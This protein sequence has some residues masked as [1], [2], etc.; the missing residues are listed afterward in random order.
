MTFH[1]FF[2]HVRNYM[3]PSGLLA[4]RAMDV[5]ERVILDQKRLSENK[6]KEIAEQ[7]IRFEGRTLTKEQAAEINPQIVLNWISKMQAQ[8]DGCEKIASETEAWLMEKFAE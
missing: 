8:R 6:R 7:T 2:S 3:L 4:G 1:D 5:G